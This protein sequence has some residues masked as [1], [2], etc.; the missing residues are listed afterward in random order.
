VTPAV[1]VIRLL[2]KVFVGGRLPELRKPLQ[3]SSLAAVKGNR[4]HFIARVIHTGLGHVEV[5][6]ILRKPAAEHGIIAARAEGRM[7]AAMAAM[8]TRA[9]VA[10]VDPATEEGFGMGQR[11]GHGGGGRQRG[12]GWLG[13]RCC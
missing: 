5:Q 13:W 2:V 4:A 7:T 1:V 9:A 8:A 11:R 6:L 12:R 10:N 3:W